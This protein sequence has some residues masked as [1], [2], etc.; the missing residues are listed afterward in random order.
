MQI[1]ELPHSGFPEVHIFRF[2]KCV[3]LRKKSRN[4]EIQK[5]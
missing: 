4:L 1:P 5:F 2:P 3:I